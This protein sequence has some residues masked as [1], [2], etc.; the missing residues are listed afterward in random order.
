MRIGLITLCLFLQS[1]TTPAPHGINIIVHSTVAALTEDFESASKATYAPADVQLTSGL[2]FFNN[3]LIG[4]IASD[5]GNGTRSA[6]IRNLGSIRMNFDHA[7]GASTIS[8]THAIFGSDGN[9]TW[10]LQVSSDAGSS[11]SKIGNTITT[12]TTSLQTTTF[13][14]NISGTFRIAIVKTGSDLNRINIDDISIQPPTGGS[15]TPS[16]GENDHISMGNPSNATT[17][18]ASPDNYLMTKSYYT[19]SY[20]STRGSPNWVSWHVDASDLD[21]FG[22]SEDFRADTSLPAGWYRVCETCY[23][24][25]GF[26][27]GHNCPSA[28]RTASFE[29]NSATFL[30]TNM[31]AQAPKLNR[32]R[33]ARLEDYGRTLIQQGNE[34]YII[35]GAYGTGGKGSK[36]SKN[37]INNGHVTVPSNVWKIILVLPDGTNDLTRVASS[38]RVIAVNMPNQNKKGSDWKQFRTTVDAIEAATGYDILSNIPFA[39]QQIIEARVDDQ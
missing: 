33:W 12:S 31:I 27:R 17:D 2:W 22:R 25:S 24:G 35:M 8:V 32:Q 19:L 21:T 18:I 28:D 14:V 7:G 38:T 5:H 16:P 39:I 23:G 3:A 4:N 26:D 36:G 34:I 9:S 29:S 6:R 11:Y 30:M 1:F 15:G 10:E 20:N 13:T 37:S